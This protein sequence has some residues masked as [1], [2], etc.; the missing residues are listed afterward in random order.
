MIQF[1][2]GDAAIHY[3]SRNLKENLMIKHVFLRQKHTEILSADILFSKAT[4]SFG[5]QH[6]GMLSHYPHLCFCERGQRQRLDICSTEE[7]VQMNE[8]SPRPG[9][10]TF[11][12]LFAA[13]PPLSLLFVPSVCLLAQSAARSAGDEGGAVCGAECGS[14]K[15]CCTA[16][17]GRRNK[18]PRPY[19]CA[20]VHMMQFEFG[21]PEI[22]YRYV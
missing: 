8:I 14:F 4:S 22:I 19:S 18:R 16:P 5:V 13:Y 15:V 12:S 10:R 20:D 17:S 9:N 2:G 21:S 11:F 3:L 6:T 1:C 7:K